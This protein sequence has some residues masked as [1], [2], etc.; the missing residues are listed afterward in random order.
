MLSQLKINVF[1]L[2][3]LFYMGTKTILKIYSTYKMT[4][5]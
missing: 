2:V 5:Y 3:I 1:K 4:Y